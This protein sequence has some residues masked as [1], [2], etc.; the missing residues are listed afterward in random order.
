MMLVETIL[1]VKDFLKFENW[2][3]NNFQIKNFQILIPD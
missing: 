1:E 3:L 2:I